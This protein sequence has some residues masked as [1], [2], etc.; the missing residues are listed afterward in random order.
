MRRVLKVLSLSLLITLLFIGININLFA[1]DY[2]EVLVNGDVS[3]YGRY[4]VK[5][6]IATNDLPYGVKHRTDISSLSASAGMVT[7]M[8]LGVTEKFVPGKEYPQQVNIMEIPVSSDVKIT[9]WSVLGNTTWNLNTVRTMASDYESKHPGYKVIGAINAD[10]F[11][12][13]AKQALP[14]TTNGAHVSNGEFY[15]SNSN[16]TVGFIN[17]GTSNSFVGGVPTRTKMILSIYDDGEMIGEYEIDKINQNPGDNQTAIY[18]PYWRFDEDGSRIL[19]K[20]SVNNAYIVGDTIHAFG[21]SANDFY[22]R[23]VITKYG[24]QELN[25]GEF[26]IITNNLDIQSKLAEGIEIRAQYKYAGAFANVTDATGAGI[27]LLKDGVLNAV[28]DTNRHPR[29]M[30]GKKADGTIVMA[31]VDGR[32]PSKAMY[33]AS[34]VE[35][36]AVMKHYGVV[37]AYNLDGGGSSTMIILKDGKFVVTNSPSDGGERTDANALLV[38]A[39]VPMIDVDISRDVNSVN[40]NAILTDKN[41]H[42][43]DDLYAGIGADIKKVIDNNVSFTSLDSNTQY[44]LKFYKQVNDNYIDLAVHYSLFTTKQTPVFKAIS[45]YYEGDSLIAL[46][47]YDDPDNAVE[48]SS[49]IIDGKTVLFNKGIATFPDFKG[50]LL[51]LEVKLEINLNDGNGRIPYPIDP[52]IHYQLDVFIGYIADKIDVKFMRL[53]E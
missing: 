50:S 53:F 51:S 32:Q 6:N 44:A 40:V 39:K 13:N 27:T 5:E 38:V 47:D 1:S 8:G 31:V 3:K 16:A 25:E 28:S 52:P 46:L 21:Y 12:I 11:D 22:G 19:N 17:D 29:T 4:Q 23:G 49:I 37:E 41:G 48:R 34:Q 14:R 43:F 18:Y 24:S 20:H 10:F 30:I 15:K 2:T 33:G 26:A 35:M 45:L 36:A 7:A 42:E 9:S